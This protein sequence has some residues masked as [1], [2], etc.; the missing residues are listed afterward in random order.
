MGSN[1][2]YASVKSYSKRG[3]LLKK[4]DFQTLSESRDLEELM[5]RIKNTVYRDQMF[6]SLILL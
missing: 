5:T 1:T 2:V 6:K 4:V 3:R